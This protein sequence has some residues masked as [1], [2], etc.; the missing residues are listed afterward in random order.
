MH[1]YIYKPLKERDQTFRSSSDTKSELRKAAA[2]IAIKKEEEGQ[3]PSVT[4]TLS[5]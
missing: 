4:C 3:F 2:L 1:D 5:L